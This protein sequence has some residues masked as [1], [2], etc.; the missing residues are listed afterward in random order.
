MTIFLLILIS[1]IA[2]L[3]GP[4]ILLVLTMPI[5]LW[6]FKRFESNRAFDRIGFLMGLIFMHLQLRLAEWFISYRGDEFHWWVALV[7]GIVVIFVHVF[8]GMRKDGVMRQQYEAM[9]WGIIIRL[10]FYFIFE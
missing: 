6:I 8:S 7:S 5:S 10:I 3:V 2:T 9:I 4:P 1:I